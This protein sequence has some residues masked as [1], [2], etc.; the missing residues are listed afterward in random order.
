MERNKIIVVIGGNRGIGAAIV[1][2]LLDHGF[3]VACLSRKGEAPEGLAEDCAQRCISLRCDVTDAASI[4]EAF[5]QAS[6]H[7]E[8]GGMVNSA[9]IHAMG[10]SHSFTPDQFLVVL[11]TNAVGMFSACQEIHPYLA[12]KKGALIVNIGSFFDKLGVPGNAAYCA[13]KA[14]VGAVTRCLAVEW[15][16]LNIRVVNVAPGYIDTDMARAQMGDESF[17]KYL[18]R[19][20]PGGSIGAPEDVGDLVGAMFANDIRFLT[21]ET[22]YVD[23]AQSIAH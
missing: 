1:V 21:G 20:I 8:I 14:A 6:G 19:R 12:G 15:A 16:P 2:A 7:G 22:I 11:Q 18:A 23:G 10:P 5:V 9:G 3:R 17:R 4:R 13:S